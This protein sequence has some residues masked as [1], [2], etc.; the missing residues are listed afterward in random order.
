MPTI[1]KKEKYS[2]V[3]VRRILLV[4]FY[5]SQLIRLS[6]LTF[7]QSARGI[8]RMPQY[9]YFVSKSVYLIDLPNG[10]SISVGIQKMPTINK[11]EKY[12]LVQV[13]RILLVNFYKSQLIRLSILTFGQSA[14][15][16][17]R[18]PQYKKRE[19]VS[20]VQAR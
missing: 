5:K 17:R 7:G 15:G 11:K 6:I 10:K 9:K 14:R 12:S 20:F 18:M 16:I 2:L 4:N 8:R 1:N 3:Q 13:R 19:K